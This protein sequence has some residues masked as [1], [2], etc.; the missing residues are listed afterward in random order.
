MT[1]PKIG[2]TCNQL[3]QLRGNKKPPSKIINSWVTCLLTHL[4]FNYSSFNDIKSSPISFKAPIALWRTKEAY[5][6]HFTT[7]Q[8]CGHFFALVFKLE[9]IWCTFIDKA[10][11]GWTVLKHLTKTSH[12]WLQKCVRKVDS[13]FCLLRALLKSKW[14]QVFSI[15][16]FSSIS[17]MVKASPIYGLLDEISAT[18]WTW[19]PKRQW[20]IFK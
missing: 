2:Y 10:S 7:A 4:S 19:L 5:G 13:I 17:P 12:N 6:H 8:F 18:W 15:Y 16:W 20:D 3:H 1:T 11:F 14:T 9:V